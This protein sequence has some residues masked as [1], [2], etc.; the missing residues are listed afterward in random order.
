MLAISMPVGYLIA[1]A[2]LLAFDKP[3]ITDTLR[4]H[5]FLTVACAA[6]LVAHVIDVLGPLD[7]FR[8]MAVPVNKGNALRGKLSARPRRTDIQ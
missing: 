3:V 1:D 6:I 5:R 7:P 2:V 8:A 4:R